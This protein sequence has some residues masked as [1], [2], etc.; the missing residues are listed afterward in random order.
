MSP[1]IKKPYIIFTFLTS[2]L[3]HKIL[4]S[5]VPN[6]QIIDNILNYK[7]SEDTINNV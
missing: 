1:D 6:F 5:D 7:T 4:N 3:E 2:Y